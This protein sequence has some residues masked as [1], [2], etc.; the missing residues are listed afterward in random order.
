MTCPFCGR[1]HEDTHPTIKEEYID[2]DDIQYVYKHFIRNEMDVMA[3]NAAE[4]AGEQDSFFEYKEI[5]YDNQETLS[6]ENLETWAEDLE[7]DMEEWRECQENLEF[8]EEMIQ[9]T[10][11]AQGFGITGTP[12]FIVNDETISGAQ[13]FTAFQTVI[14]ENL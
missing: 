14:E 10:Q 2:T 12:G 6:E 9:S 5:V 4:C 1:H 11:E 8:Q 13:P 7:L 3:G